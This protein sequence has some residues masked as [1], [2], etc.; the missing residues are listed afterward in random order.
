M[1]FLGR[2]KE[3]KGLGFG[4]GEGK[5]DAWSLEVCLLSLCYHCGTEEGRDTGGK[6]LD[7]NAPAFGER[8]CSSVE[9]CLWGSSFSGQ[10]KGL[11]WLSTEFLGCV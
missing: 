6:R 9:W 10:I 7:A 3:E 2:G 8:Q 1:K 5:E 11:E 4:G